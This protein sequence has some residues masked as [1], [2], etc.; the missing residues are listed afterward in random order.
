VS[1]SEIEKRE[2]EYKKEKGTEEKKNGLSLR[3]GQ[4]LWEVEG[5]AGVRHG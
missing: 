3:N 1:K 4:L 2:A 5:V